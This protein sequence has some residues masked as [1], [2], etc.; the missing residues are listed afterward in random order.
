MNRDKQ[1]RLALADLIADVGTELAKLAKNL[2]AIAARLSLGA[3]R[4]HERAQRQ[5]DY[6]FGDM[7]DE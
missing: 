5:K 4:E 1:R 7:T 6:D 2:E 3:A